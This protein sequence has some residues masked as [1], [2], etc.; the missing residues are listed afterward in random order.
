MLN[1]SQLRYTQK[2]TEV[3]VHVPC[4]LASTGRMIRSCHG[5]P[6]VVHCHYCI[7]CARASP[8][9]V[10][11]HVDVAVAPNHTRANNLKRNPSFSPFSP[12]G[13]IPSF[14]R[15]A[16]AQSRNPAERQRRKRRSEG[17]KLAS[18]IARVPRRS[19][20][21]IHLPEQGRAGQ[22][23]GQVKLLVRHARRVALS[24]ILSPSAP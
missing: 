20:I 17:G 16:R 7:I 8:G 12:L 5:G 24:S 2:R 10:G 13:L 1:P 22:L 4:A 3:L 19:S 23:A 18:F 11:R 14:L 15:G 9:G 6:A 21:H